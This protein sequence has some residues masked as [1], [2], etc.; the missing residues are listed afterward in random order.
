MNFVKSKNMR[1]ETKK[2]LT[3]LLSF[4]IASAGFLPMAAGANHD[5]T[6]FC[7][8]LAHRTAVVTER[9][10]KRAANV[11]KEF[12]KKPEDLTKERQREDAKTQDKRQKE[13]QK[14]EKE[15]EK[16]LKKY[17]GDELATQAVLNFKVSVIASTAQALTQLDAALQTFRTAFDAA[18]AA[19]RD[20]FL[21]AHNLRLTKFQQALASA[22]TKCDA[23]EKPSRVEEQFNKDKKTANSQFT[24]SIDAATKAFKVAVGSAKDAFKSAKAAIDSD[25]KEAIRQARENLKANMA[26][27]KPSVALSSDMQSGTAPL[28][29]NFTLTLKNLPSCGNTIKIDFGDGAA[30]AISD[31]CPGTPSVEASRDISQSHTYQNGGK[32]KARAFVSDLKSD[33]VSIAVN[34]APGANLPPVISSCGLSSNVTAV[35]KKI[36]ANYSVSDPENDRVSVKVDWGDGK[37]TN[38]GKNSDMHAYTKAGTYNVVITAQ[39]NKNATSTASCG[40]VKAG[41]SSVGLSS[42]RQSGAKP[43][44]IEFALTLNYLPSCGNKISIDFGNGTSNINDACAPDLA[45]TILESRDISQSRAYQ[46]IGTYRASAAVDKLKSSAIFITVNP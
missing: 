17:E 4:F 26:A 37:T 39:D 6:N 5:K 3:L 7:V 16:L 24:S 23:K 12:D 10:Q 1:Y 19:K 40:S 44:T 21:A 45:A 29:V 22:K 33:F 42:D 30:T 46:N 36:A 14:F 41:S 20:A 25:L 31:V 35:N 27:M 11:T 18:L 2:I 13:D 8:G 15:I 9:L 43:L 32:F 38:G 28:T 34:Q